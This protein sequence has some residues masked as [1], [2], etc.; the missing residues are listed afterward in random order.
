MRTLAILMASITFV[1]TA[2]FAHALATAD[3]PP[4][5]PHIA[6]VSPR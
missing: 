3:E 2:L 4:P 5:T 1:T 6:Q